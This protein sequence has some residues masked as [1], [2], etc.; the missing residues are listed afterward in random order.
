MIRERIAAIV[1]MALT[2]KKQ[3]SRVIEAKT[4]LLSK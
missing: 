4:A 2:Q 1:K 3:V